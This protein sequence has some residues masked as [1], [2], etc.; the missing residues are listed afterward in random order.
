[1]RIPLLSFILKSPFDEGITEH[2]EK[3]KECTWAFQQAIECFLSDKC[4]SF[5]KHRQEVIKVKSEADAIK[6][7]IRDHF[8]RLRAMSP[9]KYQLLMY[10]KEE[11]RILNSVERSLDW[12]SGNMDPGIPEHL[13]KD[14]FLLVDSII[15]PIEELSKMVMEAGSC[16]RNYSEKKR[17]KI[18]SNISSLKQKKADADRIGSAF[19]SKIFTLDAGPVTILYMIKLVE[20]IESIG[21]H[22]ENA[23]DIMQAMLA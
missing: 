18:K 11:D 22:A 3:V 15:E 21:D 20:L 19:T 12:L 6:Q 9:N 14:V 2:T 17:G 13:K 7:R 4:E 23:G 1:M 8:P 5:E 10:L 16:F